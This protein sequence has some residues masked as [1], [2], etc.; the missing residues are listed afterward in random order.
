VTGCLRE[1]ATLSSA[2]QCLIVTA[3]RAFMIAQDTFFNFK[4]TPTRI[5]LTQIEFSETGDPFI[6]LQSLITTKMMENYCTSYP[7]M[8]LVQ[9]TDRTIDDSVEK[10]HSYDE[11]LDETYGIPIE[12][13]VSKSSCLTTKFKTASSFSPK[14]RPPTKRLRRNSDIW[15]HQQ[16]QQE[17]QQQCL[18]KF[19]KKNT[20]SLHLHNL[21]STN[22][23]GDVTSDEINVKDKEKVTLNPMILVEFPLPPPLARVEAKYFLTLPK[24]RLL[25]NRRHCF[26]LNRASCE[27][28]KATKS[29]REKEG[30]YKVRDKN[31]EKRTSPFSPH[32]YQEQFL[33]KSTV[34]TNVCSIKTS[35]RNGDEPDRTSSV[36]SVMEQIQQMASTKGI[37]QSKPQT[38]KKEMNQNENF[39][40][41]KE[42]IPKETGRLWEYTC[43]QHQP[44][45]ILPT[46]PEN[47]NMNRT[48]SSRYS[49]HMTP[50]TNL[51]SSS[52][53]VCFSKVVNQEKT[54]LTKAIST[55]PIVARIPFVARFRVTQDTQDTNNP[56]SSLSSFSD[57]SPRAPPSCVQHNAMAMNH[58]TMP[59]QEEKG[60]TQM[61]AHEMTSPDSIKAQYKR[62]V[63]EKAPT[64]KQVLEQLKDLSKSKRLNDKE[65]V[66]EARKL[67]YFP[68]KEYDCNSST[69]HTTNRNPI[70]HNTSSPAFTTSTT[71]SSS[72]NHI[73]I[74]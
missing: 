54:V 50:T 73:L 58:P 39:L 16:E 2:I 62:L 63:Y 35:K 66:D 3:S 55:S 65:K 11:K 26:L 19:S 61:N 6:L 74:P 22:D 49:S 72:I 25:F 30:V 47:V 36:R 24:H 67:I 18:Q 42:N 20:G 48:L 64:P 10:R 5:F 56:P 17:D 7:P 53:S 1:F 40:L 15:L 29:T 33:R 13:D 4:R 23:K 69:K 52:P 44:S 71:T 60:Q 21:Q 45:T 57:L 12:E 51:R 68:K 38:K 14:R 28:W 9:E 34:C 27:R 41:E 43:Q 31:I 32:V 8:N 59:I 37:V 70:N 46:S